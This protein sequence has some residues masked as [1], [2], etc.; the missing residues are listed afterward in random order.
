MLDLSVSFKGLLTSRV[1]FRKVSFAVD[2]QFWSVFFFIS[3]HVAVAI[4]TNPMTMK[5]L[6]RDMV[7]V[8]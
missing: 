5:H 6:C 8:E 1:G 2:N 7:D 3:P 4:L